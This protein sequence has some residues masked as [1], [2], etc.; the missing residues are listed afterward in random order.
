[1]KLNF[2]YLLADNQAFNDGLRTFQMGVTVVGIGVILGGLGVASKHKV[3]G[4]IICILG[5]AIAAY[6]WLAFAPM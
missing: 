3:A 1:M 6:P 2:S 4:V 5:A